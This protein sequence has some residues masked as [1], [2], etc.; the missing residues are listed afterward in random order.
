MTRYNLH[1][2]L[3][4]H[5][6]YLMLHSCVEIVTFSLS[7]QT[8]NGTLGVPVCHLPLQL[9][10]SDVT[11]GAGIPLLGILGSLSCLSDIP[12]SVSEVSFK[13]SVLPLL[14]FL[15]C[16]SWSL[17]CHLWTC[18]WRCLLCDHC[19]TVCHHEALFPSSH[20]FLSPPS[21]FLFTRGDVGSWCE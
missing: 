17:H 1:L 4:I 3:Q 7:T 13:I 10:V 18:C 15:R 12:R 14:L 2:L 21:H 19:C 9:H 16:F 20:A 5:S 8:K 11:S 6:K